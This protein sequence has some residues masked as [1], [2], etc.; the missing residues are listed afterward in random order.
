MSELM[1]KASKEAYN[2]DNKGK[3]QL[4]GNVFLTKQ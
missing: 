2:K 3:M 1:K 4:I